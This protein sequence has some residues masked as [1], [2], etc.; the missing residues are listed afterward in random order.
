[1]VAS[2]PI[3]STA[4]II[5]QWLYGRPKL[6]QK[7]YLRDA[8]LGL[9]FLDNPTLEAIT[10]Q[11]LQRYQSHLIE[12]RHQQPRTINRK[13]AALRSLL[14]FAHEQEFIARNPAIALRSPKVHENLHERILTVEQVQRIIAA[15]SPG[16][17]RCLL[18]FTYITGA[19]IS[20]VCG[21][22]WKD[23]RPKPDGSL[24]VRLLG[25][26]EKWR[27]VKISAKFHLWDAISEFRGDASDDAR[28]FRLAPRQAYDVFKAAIKKGGAPLEASPHWFRHSSAS[29]SL[30][31]GA[32]IHVVR[33]T[34]GHASVQTT[35]KY[36]H[37]SP[38]ESSGD[39][40]DL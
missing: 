24:V 32:K 14:K 23:C 19:R 30:E 8:T 9:D 18:Q 12:V 3:P 15:A 33:D 36:L 5:E 38:D 13:L 29:H 21:L 34:L 11:D 31:A 7:A 40:L 28:A 26:R 6:T 20:E 39:H 27:S 25:K 22:L 17:D 35:D 10:L 2:K 16:R 1:M 37:S 4:E